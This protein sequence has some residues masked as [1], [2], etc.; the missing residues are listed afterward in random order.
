MLQ[1]GMDFEELNGTHG[2][3]SLVGYSPGGLKIQTRLSN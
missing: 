1:K 2:Q 3:R